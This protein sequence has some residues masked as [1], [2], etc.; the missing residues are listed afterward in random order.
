M[1]CE[2]CGSTVNVG[3]YDSAN[4]KICLC[5]LCVVDCLIESETLGVLSQNET[6]NYA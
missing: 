3:Q 1:E 2:D 5:R 4:G 6:A